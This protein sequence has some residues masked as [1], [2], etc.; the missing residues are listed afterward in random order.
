MSHYS[1]LKETKVSSKTL[2]K[3]VV[4]FNKDTVR[5]SNGRETTRV[6]L[7]HRGASAIFYFTA[8]T[9]TDLLIRVLGAFALA[10]R[11]G[12]DGVWYAWPIGWILSLLLVL[13]FYF[14][15]R[16]SHDRSYSETA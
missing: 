13:S 6:Y 14:W 11:F 3:G 12:A 9:F 1:K 10:P 15:G 16:W 8:S 5:L 7:A 4:G 2:Y